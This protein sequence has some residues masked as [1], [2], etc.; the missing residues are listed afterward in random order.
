MLEREAQSNRQI[1]ET[2]L[3][4]EKELRSSRTA[5]E[6]RQAD[7]R[8][9]P[10]RAVHVR[11]RRRD[12]LLA[13]V[14]GFALSLGLVFLLDYLDDTVKTPDDVTAKLRAPGLG[15]APKVR[16]QTAALLSR[17]CR[18]SSARPS[19]RCGRR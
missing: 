1:Y 12:L 8:A 14:A 7:H 9:E 5:W 11:R 10:R 4:R 13:L 15:L 18:T 2:L 17:R 19:G 16:R 3:Q 6:Q